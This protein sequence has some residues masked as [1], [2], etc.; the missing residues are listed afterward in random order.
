MGFMEITA[1]TS[2]LPTMQLQRKAGGGRSPA[3]RK[4]GV[5]LYLYLRVKATTSALLWMSMVSPAK[6]P[7]SIP[8]A[9]YEP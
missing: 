3:T 7:E 8:R 1:G 5:N 2:G 4:Y 9:T 6:A